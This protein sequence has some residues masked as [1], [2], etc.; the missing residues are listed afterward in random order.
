MRGYMWFN[1]YDD[2]GGSVEDKVCRERILLNEESLR[3]Q[4]FLA[5]VKQELGVIYDGVGDFHRVVKSLEDIRLQNPDLAP[6]A[7]KLLNRAAAI[8]ADIYRHLKYIESAGLPIDRDL[9]FT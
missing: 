8:D 5:A 1:T 6:D 3:I 9:Y 7:E 2:E 4:R